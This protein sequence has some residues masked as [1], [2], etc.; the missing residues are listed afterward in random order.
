MTVFQRSSR[1]YCGKRE[2]EFCIL[3]A[4]KYLV[5]KLHRAACPFGKKRLSFF[6]KLISKVY[7]KLQL[8]Q[9][10]KIEL[11]QRLIQLEIS[12]FI[13]QRLVLKRFFLHQVFNGL[14]FVSSGL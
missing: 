4:E 14:A 5:F 11:N 6:A 9:T 1:V 12:Q 2:C 8:H 10:T 3:I 13:A 7:K